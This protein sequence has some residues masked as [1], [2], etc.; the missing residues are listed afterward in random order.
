MFK[1][2]QRVRKVAVSTWGERLVPIGATGTIVGID[3]DHDYDWRVEYDG[4]KPLRPWRTFYAYS[5]MLA[6][7]TDPGADAFIERIKKLKPYDEPRV[8][9]QREHIDSPDWP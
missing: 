8:E 1:V 5:W 9:P 2:G 6:P 3:P 7:L 4:Y